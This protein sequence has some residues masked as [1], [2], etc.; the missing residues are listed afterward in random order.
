MHP[1]CVVTFQSLTKTWSYQRSPRI[2]RH[3][4]SYFLQRY[5][6]PCPLH[7]PSLS[8]AWC[9]PAVVLRAYFD[10]AFARGWHRT[11]PSPIN[12]VK[13]PEAT[14]LSNIPSWQTSK[15]YRTVHSIP[16]QA[17]QGKRDSS[18][19]CH[20]HEACSTGFEE[21]TVQISMHSHQSQQKICL[22]EQLTLSVTPHRSFQ[23]GGSIVLGSSASC[24]WIRTGLTACEG[25]QK[26]DFKGTGSQR[27]WKASRLLV[28]LDKAT[29]CRAPQRALRWFSASNQQFQR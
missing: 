18:Y 8:L 9:S 4:D 6:S 22:F 14:P 13:A 3:Q 7:R 27:L 25:M 29:K 28:R 12:T 11:S 20:T 19:S 16:P 23:S 5:P 15:R 1:I 2:T 10:I 24:I 21:P 17:T 26:P